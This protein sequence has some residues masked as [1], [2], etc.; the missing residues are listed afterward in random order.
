MKILKLSLLV[1]LSVFTLGLTSC[2]KLETKTHEVSDSFTNINIVSDTANIVFVPTDGGCKVVCD[3]K[4]NVLRLYADR[5]RISQ[6][7]DELG[8]SENMGRF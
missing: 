8:I 4:K 2:G 5:F 1:G 6:P 7:S 3:E